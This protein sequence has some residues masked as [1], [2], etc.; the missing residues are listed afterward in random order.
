[1]DFCEFKSH[2]D[3]ALTTVKRLFIFQKRQSAFQSMKETLKTPH[4]E[5]LMSYYTFL[6]I[7]YTS[8]LH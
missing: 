5:V 6:F 4:F 2:L 3:K 7:S 1:M 8:A